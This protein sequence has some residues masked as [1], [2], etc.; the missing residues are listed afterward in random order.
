MLKRFRWLLLASAVVVAGAAILAIQILIPWNSKAQE[1]RPGPPSPPVSTADNTT[2]SGAV[3]GLGEALRNWDL[4]LAAQWMALAPDGPFSD[5]Y[6]NILAPALA[7]MELTVGAERIQEDHAWVDVA[8]TAVD[9][10]GAL[11][12]LS[13]D[14]ASYLVNCM[15]NHSQ[16]NWSEFLEEYL[17]TASAEDML[18]VRRDATVFLTRDAAGK[19]R[20][21]ATDPQNREFCNALTGGL[22]DVLEQLEQLITPVI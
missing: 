1:H 12:N 9:M 19:W 18:R 6:H 2:P 11:G 16:A 3:L 21:D 13:A 22:L 7:R 4:G 15:I 14:A 8:V 17:S 20:I 5:A 10:G